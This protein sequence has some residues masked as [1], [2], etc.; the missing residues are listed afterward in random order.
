MI[1]KFSQLSETDIHVQKDKSLQL[2]L[3]THVAA[4]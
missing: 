4:A 1:L 2:L 3:A